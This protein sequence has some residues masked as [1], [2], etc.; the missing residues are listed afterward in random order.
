[1]TAV[2]P[3]V[4]KGNSAGWVSRDSVQ[5]VATALHFKGT[6][7]LGGKVNPGTDCIVYL[8]KVDYTICTFQ[9]LAG[10]ITGG[11][12]MEWTAPAFEEVCLNCEINSYASATL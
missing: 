2:V 10:T 7:P 6:S 11:K 5:E 12:I 8:G 9:Y 4:E 3:D 1:M